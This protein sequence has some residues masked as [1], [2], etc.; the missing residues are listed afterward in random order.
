M[1][2]HPMLSVKEAAE[3]LRIDERSVRDRLANGT[4]KGEKKQIGLRDKWFVYAGAITSALAK[5]DDMHFI[6]SSV[7]V[8]DV[9]SYNAVDASSIVVQ[10]R[11]E[12]S[13]IH[14]RPAPQPIEPEDATYGTLDDVRLQ[15]AKEPIKADWRAESQP[16]LQSLADAFMKP[17]LEKVAAQER[18]LVEQAALVAAQQKEIEEQKIQLRLLPD[19]EQKARQEA[20][21]AKAAELK[22]HEAAALQK[23]ADLLAEKK[24]RE[25]A[26]KELQV[27]ELK[28]QVA[29]VEEEKRVLEAKANEALKL[30]EN[31]QA[32]EKKVDQLQQPWWKKVFSN[33]QG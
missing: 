26:D 24:A 6:G 10:N 28:G 33:S 16:N 4:L 22:I 9:E 13:F 11:E 7:S 25:L 20:E 17:L 31:L 32:M 21:A 23:Q 14:S 15:Q 29:S 5:Q 8:Q 19:L 27:A 1:Q 30:A 2:K 3:A 18:A 12:E